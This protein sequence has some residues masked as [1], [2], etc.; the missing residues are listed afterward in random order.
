M[1]QSIVSFDTH[2]LRERIADPNRTWDEGPLGQGH[3]PETNESSPGTKEFYIGGTSIGS[4]VK[5]TPAL[6]LTDRPVPERFGRFVIVSVLGEGGMGSVYKARDIELDRE[7]AL[8]LVRSPMRDDS[9]KPD[10]FLREA[11]AMAQ[12]SH[13]NIVTIYD[14]GE[15]GGVRYIVLELVEG[16]SLIKRL[17]PGQ[18]M[19][20]NQAT[21]LVLTLARTLH[22]AHEQGILHRDLKPSNILFTK[23]GTPK[24]SDFSLAKLLEH[25]EMDE[26]EDVMTTQAGTIIGTPA[27]MAPEQIMGAI[28]QLGPATDIYSLGTMFYELLTGYRPFEGPVLK[29]IHDHLHTPP[30]PFAVKNPEIKVLAKVERLVM[31]C[32]EKEPSRRYASAAALAEELERF[33]AVE[34]VPDRPEPGLGV[35]FANRLEFLAAEP[36]LARPEGWFRKQLRRLFPFKRS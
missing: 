15:K 25:H 34:P 27:Y 2:S 24:I 12:L 28:D 11:K 21:H 5:E 20:L 16:Y 4:A 1:A 23:D 31:R 7:V 8:K 6:N 33:L 35:D 26:E 30:P 22:Y 32:L 9:S 13:P 10:R 18:P 19:P 29:V 36:I 14:V 17:I 3:A